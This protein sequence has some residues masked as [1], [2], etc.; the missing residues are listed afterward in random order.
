MKTPFVR[1]Q[2]LRPHRPY[3]PK[4]LLV[5]AKDRA[6]GRVASQLAIL[7][8]GKHKPFFTPH[9]DVGDFVVVINADKVKLTGAKMRDKMYYH[10]TGWPG[11][12]KAANAAMLFEKKPLEPLRLAVKRMLPKTILG[13]G[14]LGKLKLY[15]GDEHP[16]EAQNPIPY[17]IEKKP[18]AF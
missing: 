3:A 6:L 18:H 10:H 8:R 13:R 14:M 11:G 16:H 15:A 1:A 12:L 9:V 7:L 17:A 2:D 4:W 5:D